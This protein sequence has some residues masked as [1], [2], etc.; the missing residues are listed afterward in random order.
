M[1]QDNLV[2][3]RRR[4][5]LSQEELAERVGVSRQTLSKWESGESAPDLERAA[6]LAEAFGV[7]LDG[8]V[9]YECTVEGIGVPPRGK[10]IFGVVTVGEKG[11]IVIPAAARKVFGV[12]PGDRLLVLGDESQGLAL[13][14][15]K[16]IFER[17]VK[18]FQ[19]PDE[20]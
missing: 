13:M 4:A 19:Q 3:L 10:H 5:G 1:F 7:T 2:Q 17:L 12:E 20:G 9:N 8:L 16:D 14:R 18:P 15:E 6:A 11:Q